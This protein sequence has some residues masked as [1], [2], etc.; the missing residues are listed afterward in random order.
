[1]KLISNEDNYSF[2]T[3]SVLS[4]PILFHLPSLA[5]CK[6]RDKEIKSDLNLVSISEKQTFFHPLKKWGQPTPGPT[7]IN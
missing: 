1:M 7:V 3:S 5:F 6:C 4:N 2:C